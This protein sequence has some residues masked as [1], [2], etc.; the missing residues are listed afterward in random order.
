MTT[1][2]FI[3]GFYLIIGAA[4]VIAALVGEFTWPIAI[5]A[6]VLILAFAMWV[7]IRS[8]RSMQKSLQES[9]G[10]SPKK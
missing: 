10:T 6:F 8:G 7:M 4:L 1:V 3:V 9:E 2:I 5:A